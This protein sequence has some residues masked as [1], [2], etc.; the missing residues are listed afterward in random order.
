MQFDR[1]EIVIR[2]RNPSELMDLAIRVMQRHFLP[3]TAIAAGL[4]IPFLLY[5]ILVTRWMISEDAILT[6]EAVDFP[7]AY[8]RIRRGLHQIILL[9]VEFPLISIPV[10]MFLGN[11]TFYQPLTIR[12]AFTKLRSIAWRVIW[13]LGICRLGL[14]LPLSELFI[15]RQ[16]MFDPRIELPMLIGFLVV[17]L[18]R[19][20][21]PFA[22]E[23]L[24]LELCPLRSKI[25]TTITYSQR[26]SGLHYAGGVDHFWRHIGCTLATMVL[27]LVISIA[28]F[29]LLSAVFGALL[30][31]QIYD[32]I[33]MPIV[34]AF[35][36]LFAIVFRF[37]SYLDSR[38]RL[39]GWELDLRLRAEGQRV[40][41]SIAA[42]EGHID[43]PARLPTTVTQKGGSFQVAK[44]RLP[45]GMAS[46]VDA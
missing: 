29:S 30:E 17:Y 21:W 9:T 46:G 23:I 44:D 1:T 6:A 16:L 19:G 4:A 33:L 25:K 18:V 7:E 22:P 8:Q 13:V 34:W 10:T 27:A 40:L 45:G 15:D 38:I 26:R 20:N 42:A 12:Q 31:S 2:Q 32:G 37:L 28:L 5:N 14:V 11:Q 39:E 41:D 36:S 43:R 3:M 24:G 35:A